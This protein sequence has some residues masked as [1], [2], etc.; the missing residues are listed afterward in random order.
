MNLAS[1]EELYSLQPAQSGKVE[2]MMWHSAN[3]GDRN[4][5]IYNQLSK[6]G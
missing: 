4:A 2:K 6:S 1:R 3:I 5:K